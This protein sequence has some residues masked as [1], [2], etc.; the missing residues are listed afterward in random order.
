MRTSQL[1]CLCLA[2]AISVQANAQISEIS[3]KGQTITIDG[4]YQSPTPAERA[5]AAPYKAELD[6]WYQRAKEASGPLKRIRECDK[7]AEESTGAERERWLQELAV[8]KNNPDF[9]YQAYLEADRAL[10]AAI[11]RTLQSMSQRERLLNPLMNS[12][13]RVVPYIAARENT[14]PKD[15]SALD[16]YRKAYE[17]SRSS[18]PTGPA[19]FLQWPGGQDPTFDEYNSLLA[20]VERQYGIMPGFFHAIAWRESMGNVQE[21]A[22]NAD[23]RGLFQIQTTDYQPHFGV[24]LDEPAGALWG[25]FERYCKWVPFNLSIKMHGTKRLVK[26]AEHYGFAGDD[27]FELAYRFYNESSGYILFSQE[28]LK[29]Y[30]NLFGLSPADL[31]ENDIDILNRFIYF[32][33]EE[34]E[35]MYDW[36]MPDGQNAGDALWEAWRTARIEVT[37][38][39]VWKVLLQ[40]LIEDK[41]Y[42]TL[43]IDESGRRW[44]MADLTMQNIKRRGSI[45]I[46][47]LMMNAIGICSARGVVPTAKIFE[48][49]FYND[50]HSQGLVAQALPTP[51]ANQ[52]QAPVP[53]EEKLVQRGSGAPAPAIAAQPM[54]TPAMP[55]MSTPQDLPIVTP[56]PVESTPQATPAPTPA[57]VAPEAGST[58]LP[59]IP[60]SQAGQVP[61]APEIVAAPPAPT[62]SP[63][64]VVPAAA[65]PE[66]QP[67]AASQPVI[68]VSPASPPPVDAPVEALPVQY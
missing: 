18:Q 31:H 33:R 24:P 38:D 52:P 41:Q 27:R 62:P 23:E 61:P 32:Q 26:Q 25:E 56:M 55:V 65:M 40:R 42:F 5:L 7:M 45:G 34:L 48:A 20:A 58:P 29:I 11:G 57:Y 8:A 1:L 9:Q 36:T 47:G 10:T 60:L 6:L 53:S 4:R 46:P 66:A 21:G 43:T 35:Q 63:A 68:E 59:A 28:R 16:D 14:I 17:S 13:V 30:R 3:V 54:A 15:V 64:V 2:L 67:F 50:P 12:Y 39:L 22:M 51:V 19:T 49:Y 37:S 44:C